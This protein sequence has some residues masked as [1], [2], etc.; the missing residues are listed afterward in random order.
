AIVFAPKQIEARTHRADFRYGEKTIPMPMMRLSE[1]LRH[2]DFNSLTDEFMAVI[3]K[4]ALSLF[5]GENNAPHFVDNNHSI[6]RSI[7][8]PAIHFIALRAIT[9]LHKG[10]RALLFM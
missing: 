2:K 6:G 8:Q 1:T 10:T 5:I 3:A 4:Q 9:K 7:E